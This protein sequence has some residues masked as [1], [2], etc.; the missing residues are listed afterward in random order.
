MDFS[1]ASDGSTLGTFRLT[2]HSGES[3]F[4]V[5]VFQA[6]GGRV[7][8]S[9][10]ADNISD[11]KGPGETTEPLPRFRGYFGGFDFPYIVKAGAIGQ[12][13]VDGTGLIVDIPVVSKAPDSIGVSFTSRDGDAVE[14][15]FPIDFAVSKENSVFV[16]QRGPNRPRIV[17]LPD[18]SRLQVDSVGSE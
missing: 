3:F 17:V 15:F 16:S 9:L 6:D 2:P 12:W 8:V 4:T 10:S 11:P 13:T 5:A 18:N 7:S 14:V 1:V